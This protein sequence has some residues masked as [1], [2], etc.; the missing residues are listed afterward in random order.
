MERE[1]RLEDLD[2]APG[3]DVYVGRVGRAQVGGMQGAVGFERLGVA[4]DD[5]LAGHGPAN[6]EA[7]P[8]REVLTE[9]DELGAGGGAR[10]PNGSEAPHHPNRLVGR[11][12]E[13]RPIRAQD[14]DVAPRPVVVARCVPDVEGLAGVVTLALS[15]RRPTESVPPARATSRRWRRPCGR[16]RGARPQAAQTFTVQRYAAREVSGGPA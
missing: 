4:Q 2:G 11:R 5:P 7:D 14:A 15:G 3:A 8:P 6:G 10:D 16:P 9:V 13:L 12:H 1:P